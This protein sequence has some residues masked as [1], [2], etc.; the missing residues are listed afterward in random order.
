MKKGGFGKGAGKMHFTK[1]TRVELKYLESKCAIA[2]F[3]IT[4]YGWRKSES[5]KWEV[6][7]IYMLPAM[8]WRQCKLETLGL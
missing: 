6:S 4:A 7:H 8:L 5:F 2:S 1:A 3:A